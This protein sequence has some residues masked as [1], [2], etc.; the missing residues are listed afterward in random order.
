MIFTCALV[1]YD[2]GSLNQAR[3][4]GRLHS[5]GKNAADESTLAQ[6]GIFC[7]LGLV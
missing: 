1:R 2:P 3:R 4:N 5:K 6:P 7:N